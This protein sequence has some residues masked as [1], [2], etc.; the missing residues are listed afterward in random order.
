MQDYSHLLDGFPG[1]T[2]GESQAATNTVST[3]PQFG[4]P[5]SESESTAG[6]TPGTPG[7]VTPL[8]PA[9]ADTLINDETHPNPPDPYSLNAPTPDGGRWT[10]APNED[11]PGRSG[12]G[13]WEKA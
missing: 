2:G 6:I 5:G 9:D 3:S 13:P 7:P 1:L 4:A 8:P 10:T 12:T 11:V